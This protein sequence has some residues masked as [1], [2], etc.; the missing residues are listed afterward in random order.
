MAIVYSIASQKGGTG[1]TSTSIS[2]A[3]GLARQGKRV[4]LID[5]DSQAN[6]SKVLIPDYQPAIRKEDS[7]YRTIVERQPLPIHPTPSHLRHR[8]LPYSAVRDGRPA[9]DRHRSP[10]KPPESSVG[11]VKEDYDFVFIDCP[12]A[13]SWLT[14][15]AFTASDQII[16]VICPGYFELES[17][18]QICKTI[19]EVQELFNPR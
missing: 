13:L 15:N 10:R 19:Q 12:P 5:I 1:K 4:L 18:I 9:H 7:L 8:A 6:A 16:V 14:I 3:A 17:T 11:S 2:L